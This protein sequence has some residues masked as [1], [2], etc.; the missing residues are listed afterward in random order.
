[1]AQDC[2]ERLGGKQPNGRIWIYLVP[3]HKGGAQGTAPGPADRRALEKTRPGGRD[4]ARASAPLVR[5]RTRPGAPALQRSHELHRHDTGTDAK[6]RACQHTQIRSARISS[7]WC[8]TVHLY[9]AIACQVS[10]PTPTVAGEISTPNAPNLAGNDPKTPTSGA[11]GSGTPEPPSAAQDTRRMP[12]LLAAPWI[13]HR[14]RQL[15]GCHPERPPAPCNNTAGRAD[16]A[17][18]FK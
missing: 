6:L 4:K 3:G 17:L 5:K 14:G 15:S 16:T 11:A 10:L 13:A 12:E 1:M 7:T 2:A 18:R 8:A 9:T